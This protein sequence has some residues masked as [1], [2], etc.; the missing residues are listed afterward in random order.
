MVTFRLRLS[1]CHVC[2]IQEIFKEGHDV[3]HKLTYWNFRCN[4]VIAES[5]KVL[6]CVL[7]SNSIVLS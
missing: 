1:K 5:V 7:L 3:S 6:M 4:Y 2:E